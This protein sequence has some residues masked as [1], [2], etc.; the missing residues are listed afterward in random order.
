MDV[1]T[2][3]ERLLG[4]VYDAALDVERWP[5]ALGG[6]DLLLRGSTCLSTHD[7]AT[8]RR[9]GFTSGELMVRFLASYNE[10]YARLNPLWPATVAAPAGTVLID[11]EV[12]GRDAFERSEF[13]NDFGRRV[14]LHAG[15]AVK[16]LDESS[17]A[18]VL[19]VARGRS[20]GEFDPADA[21]LLSRL[22]PHLHRAV[23]VNRRLSLPRGETEATADV[24]DRLPHAAMLVDAAARVLFANGAARSILA[25]QDG[26][27]SDPDGLRADT[28]AQTNDLRRRIGRAAAPAGGV[29]APP[30]SLALA[31]ASGRRPLSALVMPAAARGA[32]RSTPAALVFVGDPELALAAPPE[33]L[34]R[35]Y[36]LTHAEAAV[37]LAL[38][39]GDGM[40]VVADTL[41]V[42]LATVKTHLQ[43]VFEKTG[44]RR[45]AE[46]VSVLLVGGVAG[47]G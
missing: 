29:E 46:L 20:Q 32:A 25:A 23:Q 41:G 12:A 27:R 42:T 4:L 47:E 33:R 43:H 13:R 44:T 16:V 11:R 39:R 28:P 36:G 26:L 31:R 22:A 34:W 45:Q 18:A 15:M 2:H 6:L 9:D 37:A 24:L 3:F 17:V 38:L 35:L 14:G 1:G 40:R 7:S 5:D 10:H 19:V 8:Q 30:G 21:K